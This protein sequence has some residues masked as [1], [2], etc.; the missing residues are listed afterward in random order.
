MQRT[1]EE[2]FFHCHMSVG[3]N[4]KYGLNFPWSLQ[5]PRDITWIITWSLPLFIVTWLRMN[6]TCS[7]SPTLLNNLGTHSFFV[8]S[9]TWFSLMTLLAFFKK[10]VLWFIILVLTLLYFGYLIP[11]LWLCTI[12]LS[13]FI[14]FIRMLCLYP[15]RSQPYTH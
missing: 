5:T 2:P 10:S 14:L 11:S 8:K 7:Q 6:V 3:V 13:V 9:C 4:W 1:T 12:D 15:T